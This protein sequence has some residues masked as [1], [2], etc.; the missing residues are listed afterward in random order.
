M[1]SV[2]RL[3]SDVVVVGVR[4]QGQETGTLD[5]GLQHALILGFGAGD[6]ARND[7]AVFGN[8]LAQGVQV[9]VIDAGGAFG[10]EFAEFAAT[11]KLDMWVP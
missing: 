6:A 2:Q 11:E 5:G 4:N 3:G 7:L 1:L 10:G 8:V 9:F